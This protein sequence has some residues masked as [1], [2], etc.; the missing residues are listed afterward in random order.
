LSFR[1]QS[2]DSGGAEDGG[3]EGGGKLHDE[4]IEE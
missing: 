1:G 3:K 2:L 4:D